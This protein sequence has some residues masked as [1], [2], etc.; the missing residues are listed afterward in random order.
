AD[1]PELKERFIK[2]TL[3]MFPPEIIKRIIRGATITCSEDPNFYDIKIDTA[4]LFRC[5]NNSTRVR[6]LEVEGIEPKADFSCK[7]LAVLYEMKEPDW[8]IIYDKSAPY[9]KCASE[10][11]GLI[12]SLKQGERDKQTLLIFE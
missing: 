9:E 3:E 11:Y 8:R 4:D 10:R 12:Y 1:D 5:L 7:Y 6:I 2:L